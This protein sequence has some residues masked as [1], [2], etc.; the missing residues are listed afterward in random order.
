MVIRRAQS[1]VKISWKKIDGSVEII[2]KKLAIGTQK[3]KQVFKKWIISKEN[4]V[5]EE[6]SQKK[7]SGSAVNTP[8]SGCTVYTKYWVNQTQY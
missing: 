6:S 1:L 8:H 5:F 7:E 2:W 4:K 3:I